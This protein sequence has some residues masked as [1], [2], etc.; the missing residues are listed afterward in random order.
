[1]TP[2]GYMDFVAQAINRKYGDTRVQIIGIGEEHIR[3]NPDD[4]EPL[5]VHNA[6]RA[7]ESSRPV[8]IFWGVIQKGEVPEGVTT[9]D[10]LAEHPDGEVEMYLRRSCESTFSVKF[11]K[12]GRLNS[13]EGYKP[14]EDKS[15]EDNVRGALDLMWE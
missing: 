12:N 1:M 11:D 7:I 2:T 15:L 14:G 3:L 6:V 9:I 5:C 8:K 10:E 13:S 4:T